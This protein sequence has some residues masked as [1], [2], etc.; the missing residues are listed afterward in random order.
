MATGSQPPHHRPDDDLTRVSPAVIAR[1]ISPIATWLD[2]MATVDQLPF[3]PSVPEPMREEIAACWQDLLGGWD[4]PPRLG[5]D[6]TAMFEGGR[7][8]VE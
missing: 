3:T 1:D 5:C 4:P 6:G 7:S 2:A 8:R